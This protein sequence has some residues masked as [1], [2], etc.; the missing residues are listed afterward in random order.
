[1]IRHGL[2]AAMAM[3]LTSHAAE[4]RLGMIGLDTSHSTAFTE[5]LNNP[6]AKDH[7]PGEIGRAHV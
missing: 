2:L 5:I 4:L 6:S 7:V 3:T 1:M